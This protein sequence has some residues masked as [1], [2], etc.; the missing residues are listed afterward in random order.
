MK[1]VSA[2]Q[3]V[4]PHSKAAR[5]ITFLLLITVYPPDVFSSTICLWPPPHISTSPCTT[6]II[7][8][9]SS[10]LPPPSF[11]FLASFLPLLSPRARLSIQVFCVY[12]CG[13][14]CG[15]Q[16][17]SYRGRFYV[18]KSSGSWGW[19]ETATGSGCCRS[20]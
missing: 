15:G 3:T 19:D 12:C 7:A 2:L 1:R 11:S 9:L 4:H 17:G 10:S 20:C 6:L 16:A 14:R 5:R 18:R 13:C 8:R